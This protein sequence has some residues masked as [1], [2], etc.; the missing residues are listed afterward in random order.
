MRPLLFALLLCAAAPAL[1]QPE[2]DRLR[3]DAHA[4]FQSGAYAEA[5]ALLRRVADLRT[6][7]HGAESLEAAAA[8]YDL[9]LALRQA[10]D[11]D[12]S[13]AAFE[14]ALTV[15]ERPGADPADLAATLRELAWTLYEAGRYADA[16]V[17]QRRL[18]GVLEGLY[19]AEGT[20][21]ATAHHNLGYLLLQ[22]G[23]L[24]AA[25]PE[26]DRAL[27]LRRALH[28]PGD[29]NLVATLDALAD[30]HRA[31]GDR[32]RDAG[33][34][35][36]ADVTASWAAYDRALAFADEARGPRSEAS[37]AV[38]LAMTQLLARFGEVAGQDDGAA[39]A[40]LGLDMAR[41]SEALDRMGALV[42]EA[43]GPDH[44]AL[45]MFA[46]FR[47]Q[48]RLAALTLAGADDERVALA[49]ELATRA[50][51]AGDDAALADALGRLGYAHRDAGAFAEAEAA[52]L[53][54]RA[55]REAALGPD[56]PEVAVAL[57]DLGGLYREAGRLADARRHYEQALAVAERALTPG[58]PALADYLDPL[59]N[60][61]Y[62]LGDMQQAE[63]L[64]ERAVAMERTRYGDDGVEA[65]LHLAD[66]ARF[67][68][69]EGDAQA[70]RAYQE[71][72]IALLDAALERSPSEVA[73]GLLVAMRGTL[74]QYLLVLGEEDEARRLLTASLD[75]ARTHFGAESPTYAYALGTQSSMLFELGDYD[76]AAD[77][78]AEGL[79]L[80]EAHLGAD[81]PE[82]AAFRLDLGHVRIVQRRFDE[83]AP[84]LLEAAA[85]YDRYVRDV[86]PSL[87]LAE[88][89]AFLESTLAEA[90]DLLIL[91]SVVRPDALAEAYGFFGGWKGLLLRGV[92]R[93]AAAARL[94]GDPAHAADVARLQAVRAEIAALVQ[95][96]ST[97]D[98][99]AWAAARDRLTAEKE[100]LERNLA[101]A[102]PGSALED[103]WTDAG[104]LAQR[105]PAGT[106]LVD[107]YRHGPR[108][109]AVVTAA[110]GAPLLV[111]LGPAEI[112]EAAVAAWRGAVVR[113]QDA[114]AEVG[115]LGD[116]LLFPVLGALPAGADD[117]REAVWFSS[118][119]ALARVPWTHL[120]MVYDETE[121]LLVAEVP[122]ARTLLTLL[123]DARAAPGGPVLLVGGVDFDAGVTDAAGAR[124]PA[125]PGTQAEVDAIAA[126]ARQESL[127]A[128]A[129]TG[130]A[131]T[132][133]AVVAA[134]EGAAVAHFATHGFFYGDETTPVAAAS[135]TDLLGAPLP[136][137]AD[138]TRNPLTESGLALAGA[139]AGPAGSLSAE[140]IVGLDL[141]GLGLAVLSACET[142][143][144][145]EVTGQGVL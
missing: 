34:N 20:E 125:L 142:G 127:R 107:V 139:N 88:Q 106:A 132:P 92:A 144:G 74:G 101:A 43:A 52:F 69:A 58:D 119:A 4:H 33:L 2:A 8:H 87:S 16:A 145:T 78:R 35:R 67:R 115:V 55:L 104:A 44:P 61:L 30:L 60:L 66:R 120:A 94:A 105:L 50:E 89:R 25:E 24:D 6:A 42:E 63:A 84:L 111:D 1:A 45:A 32:L 27:T 80:L 129:L 100:R 23:D 21:A 81:H 128:E 59:A 56:A 7:A 85:A 103:P 134:L 57:R 112:V 77:A 37:G 18:V 15:R 36:T 126:V 73:A 3:D 49:R 124:W 83:A 130:A 5:A 136:A 143:R 93:Q 68:A 48:V 131:A 29:A 121:P 137:E 38:L 135:R 99:A 70:A 123:G 98:P 10:G 65:A 64:T 28:P 118:D 54:A 108:Y 141:S 17:V 113:G 75:Y 97:M 22:T 91:I 12:G 102:L 72:A 110:G 62:D 114:L 133:A 76:G 9:G 79:A 82:T 39:N 26:L 40:L 138:M 96:A 90:T 11:H 122:S 47:D 13:R 140:E 53:R 51:A 71:E 109:S 46:Q 95:Q 19:G 117:D 14:A 41:F 86:L 31:R 116:R